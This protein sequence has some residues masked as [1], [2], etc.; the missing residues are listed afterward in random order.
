[1]LVVAVVRRATLVRRVQHPGCVSIPPASYPYSTSPC[2][3]PPTTRRPSRRLSSTP[4]THTHTRA[5][6]CRPTTRPAWEA[7]RA[8]SSNSRSVVPPGSASSSSSS[9]PPLLTHPPQFVQCLANPVYLNHLAQQK[10]LDKPEFVAYLAYLQYFQAPPYAKFL[11]CVPSS[12]SR[13]LPWR[14]PLLIHAACL[15]L[16]LQPSRP[17]PA[18]PG[19]APARPFSEGDLVPAAGRSPR[20]PRPEECAA[21]SDS[22]RPCAPWA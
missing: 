10:M 19:A 16:A 1:M 15:S 22:V 6:S 5:P 11:Q 8:S 4:H 18:R 12:P 14:A 20:P 21:E 13:R 3:P 2:P 7:T 17:D 9:S